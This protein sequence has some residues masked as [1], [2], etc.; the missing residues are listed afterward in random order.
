MEVIKLPIFNYIFTLILVN[1]IV[2]GGRG[3]SNIK[4]IFII[5]VIIKRIIDIVVIGNGYNITYPTLITVSLSLTIKEEEE[6]ILDRYAI[7]NNNRVKRLKTG[8][9]KE[10]TAADLVFNE[11]QAFIL[12]PTFSVKSAAR[13]RL[14]LDVIIISIKT[15]VKTVK[16]IYFIK[17]DPTIDEYKKFELYNFYKDLLAY[18]GFDKKF[19]KVI[20]FAEV[21]FPPMPSDSEK[22][23]KDGYAYKKGSKKNKEKEKEKEKEKGKKSKKK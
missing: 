7:V 14:K 13:I 5:S 1:F 11:V 16:Y 3:R 8:P 4:E 21:T 22:I 15:V 6:E 9:K 20:R 18:N 23:D 12:I 17:K 2:N 19:D 10:K